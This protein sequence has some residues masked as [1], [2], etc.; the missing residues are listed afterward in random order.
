MDHEVRVIIQWTTTAK[1]ALAQL[2][3][4]VRRGLCEQIDNLRQCGDPRKAHKPLCGPLRGYYR[5]TYSRY[6]AVYTC[7]EESLPNG[8]VL[9]QIK[10]V[11]VAVGIRKEGDKGD[12]YK[13][14]QKLVEMGVLEEVKKP[15]RRPPN[16][17]RK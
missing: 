3:P 9:V 7:S 12:V 4:K 6:R 1:D 16:P 15:E 13:F 14:A 17:P 2:P 8:D 10:V 5:V 11:V